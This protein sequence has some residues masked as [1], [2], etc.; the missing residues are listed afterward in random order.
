MRRAEREMGTDFALSVVSNCEYAALATVNEDGTPYCMTVSPVVVG[1]AVYFHCA[2][3]GKKL[4][5]I[6]RCSKVCI[7]CVQ[8][9]RLV[10]E[11]FTTNYESAVATGVCEVITDD[12]EKIMALR[13]ICEKYAMSN[14][15]EFDSAIKKSLSRTTV[16]KITIEQLTGKAKR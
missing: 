2:P 13:A 4:D 10:P 16:C 6:T 12:N 3:V 15:S 5:N 8:N 1:G 7:S 9:T 14:M 11:Q